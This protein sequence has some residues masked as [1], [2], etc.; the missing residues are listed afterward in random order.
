MS[1]STETAYLIVCLLLCA[2]RSVSQE[3]YLLNEWEELAGGLEWLNEK[4][5]IKL[6]RDKKIFELFLKLHLW[7]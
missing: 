6:I 7:S 5:N 2:I 3:G 1:D 4:L